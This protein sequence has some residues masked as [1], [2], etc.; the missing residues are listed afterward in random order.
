ME[1]VWEDERWKKNFADLAEWATDIFDKA[2]VFVIKEDFGFSTWKNKK[3]IIN[4]AFSNDAHVQKL[5]AEF[6]GKDAPTNVLS[7]AN[8]DDD[9][10]CKLADVSDEVELG[11]I[12]V[13]WETLEKEAKEK[14][15]ELK[16]HFAHLLVHGILHLFGFDHMYDEE[17][18]EMEAIEIILLKQ[19]DINN[20]YEE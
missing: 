15:I 6:R 1:L 17:A 11:D 18:E 12:I 5:N 7:F 16:N 8:I 20:P 14:G 13:A 2:V 19:F 9:A 10:F 3:I 4:L